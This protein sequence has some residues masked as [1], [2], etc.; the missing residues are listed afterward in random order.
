MLLRL[1]GSPDRAAAQRAMSAMMK[2]TKL[3]IAALQQAYDD[4]MRCA[5]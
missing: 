5:G 2:M 4:K 3:D 1:F